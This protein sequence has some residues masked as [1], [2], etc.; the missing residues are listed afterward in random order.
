MQEHRNRQ[1]ARASQT[2]SDALPDSA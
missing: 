2:V 1:V